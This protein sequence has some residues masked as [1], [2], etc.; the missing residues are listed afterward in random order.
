MSPRYMKSQDQPTSNRAT[1]E[2]EKFKLDLRLRLSLNQ[3]ELGN[4][5]SKAVQLIY[6]RKKNLENFSRLTFIQNKS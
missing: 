5:Y 6:P 3:L 1:R 2:N 4:I